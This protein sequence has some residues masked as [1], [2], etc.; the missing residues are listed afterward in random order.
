MNE[1]KQHERRIAA[2]LNACQSVS[3]EDLERY[4]ETGAGIDEALEEASLRNQIKTAQE[5]DQLLAATQKIMARLANML[6]E[7]Q[8]AHIEQI[9]TS[10]GVKPPAPASDGMTHYPPS[11]CEEHFDVVTSEPVCVM[12]M[13]NEIEELE[14]KLADAAQPTAGAR[15][16]VDHTLAHDMAL[17]ELIGK[18]VPELDGS[19]ADVQAASRKLDT[20]QVV[21]DGYV[22]VPVDA[23]DEMVDAGCLALVGSIGGYEAGKVY[24][25]W[26]AMLSAAQKQEGVQEEQP[27]AT[28]WWLASLDKYGNPKL[29]DGAHSERAGANRALYLINSLNLGAGKKFAVVK[30]QLFDAEPDSKGAN[31]EALATLSAAQIGGAA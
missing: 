24:K 1:A 25:C 17:L 8:F 30:V 20:M 13:S 18:I 2:C 15:V 22:P 19:I 12:C 7:D 11:V 16:D 28:Q 9:A 6:D 3:T 21:P 26:E 4:Y 31:H 23:S 14:R 29:E 10:A 5:K 27:P